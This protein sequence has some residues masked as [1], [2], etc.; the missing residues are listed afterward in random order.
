MINQ[1]LTYPGDNRFARRG[2]NPGIVPFT[3]VRYPL[4]FEND[5]VP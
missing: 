5:A 3:A 4:V 2:L 1:A